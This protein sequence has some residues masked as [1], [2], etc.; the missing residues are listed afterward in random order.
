MDSPDAKISVI[1]G[2]LP[3]SGKSETGRLLSE[4][5]GLP[6]VD[7]DEEVERRAG[8]ITSEIFASD[9]EKYFRKLECETFLHLLEDDTNYVISL[10]GG[11]LENEQTR[12]AIKRMRI[13][14]IWLRVSPAIAGMRL[15]GA[16]MIDI[17]PLLN[18]LRME[19]LFDRL[20]E[21]GKMRR[22]NYESSDYVVD[23]DDLDPPG[24]A[25]RIKEWLDSR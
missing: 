4:I 2:G 11:T 18:G 21:L 24:V 1:L 17:H 6:F 25:A 23:T 13:P 10:G 3:G 19:T 16:G 12:Q 7:L 22:G 8:R 9:G 5:L 15:T 20:E 14:L